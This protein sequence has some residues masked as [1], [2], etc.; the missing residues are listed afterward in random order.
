MSSQTCTKTAGKQPKPEE[1][2]VAVTQQSQTS[3]SQTP[4]TSLEK[5]LQHKC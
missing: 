4:V 1:K 5:M 2:Q 3:V